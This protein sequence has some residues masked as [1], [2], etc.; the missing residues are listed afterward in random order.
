[1][2]RLVS[3]LHIFYMLCRNIPV[4]QV[5]KYLVL[6]QVVA[7][8]SA[9]FLVQLNKNRSLSGS[10]P[11][12]WWTTS[13]RSKR[14][15]VSKS[16][17]MFSFRKKNVHGRVCSCL[18]ANHTTGCEFSDSYLS[19]S[20]MRTGSESQHPRYAWWVTG[21][22]LISCLAKTEAA[23]RSLFYQVSSILQS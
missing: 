9:Q 7:Q 10:H 22:I 3:N 2:G 11:L 19:P 12:S 14:L 17:L 16:Q 8:W 21:W 23:R 5:M 1:M 18:S 15:T 6:D 4:V 13:Q 20:P